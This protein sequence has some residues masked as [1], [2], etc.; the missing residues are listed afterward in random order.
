MTFIVGSVFA[1]VLCISTEGEG[2]A[3]QRVFL[4]YDLR[5]ALL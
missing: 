2:V 5:A 3:L 4:A 1:L